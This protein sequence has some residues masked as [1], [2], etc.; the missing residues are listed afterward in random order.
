MNYA[1]Q[2]D[3]RQPKQIGA[4][5]VEEARRSTQRERIE[6]DIQRGRGERRKRL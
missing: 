1:Q 2:Q 3:Y 4:D 5:Q 6:D